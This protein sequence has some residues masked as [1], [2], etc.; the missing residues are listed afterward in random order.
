MVRMVASVQIAGKSIGPGHPCFLIA[1]IGV[2]HNGDRATAFRLI[3]A[4]MNAGADAV[5]FQTFEAKRLVT[6]NAPKAAYQLKSGSVKESQLDML[7]RLQLSKEDHQSIN[8]YCRAQGIMFLSTPF[9][10]SCSDFLETL[11]VPA[12]KIASGELTDLALIRHIAAKRKPLI[13]SSGMATLDEVEAAIRTVSEAGNKQVILLHCVSNYPA[14]PSEVNLRVIPQMAQ[15]FKIPV[16]YSDH[17]LGTDIAVAAVALGACVIEKHLTLD[18]TG[19]GPDHRASLEP[20]EF[21]ALVKAA[22]RVE[23]AL[24]HGRKEPAPS[25]IEMARIA[26]KSLVAA[27]DIP[28]GASLKA[29]WLIAQ[30]PGTGLSPAFLDKLIGR[31]AKRN[32]PTGT[33]LNEEMLL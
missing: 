19:P 15:H 2:N 21:S 4:A 3:D 30:R 9:D 27:C 6:Q 33:L 18:R 28:A 32:I 16:G 20:T 31:K 22:R 1:E 26:R 29:E 10:A 8:D 13:I 7:K 11:G 24:G 5:K 12:F 23:T 14:E 25:E 17:T